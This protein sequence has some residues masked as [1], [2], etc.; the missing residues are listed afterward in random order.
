MADLVRHSLRMNPDRVLV[1]ETLGEEVID[2]LTAMCQGQRGVM[3][4]I[5]ADS[6]ESAL[7][8]LGLYANMGGPRALP[9]ATTARLAALALDFVVFLGSHRDGHR[10][11]RYVS[12]VLELTGGVSGE[13]P[14]TL[15]IFRPG[16][17][18]RAVPGCPMRAGT[19]ADVADAG[20]DPG[21][22]DRPQGWWE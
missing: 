4:T 7:T 14:E 15:E 22:L 20:F 16:P 18:G 5:H 9:F 2:L 8:R 19:L 11:R 10:R 1:G 17:D 6:A 3:S 12:A 21:L 13:V